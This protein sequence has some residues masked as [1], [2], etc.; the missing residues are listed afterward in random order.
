MY[1]RKLMAALTC[2]LLLA[3]APARAQPGGVA[4]PERGT[5]GL[6]DLE[7]H[8]DRPAPEKDVGTRPTIPEPGD[9]TR[10]EPDGLGGATPPTMPRTGSTH[11]PGSPTEM[12]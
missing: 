4:E 8:G 2:G 11:P 1:T 7:G 5:R 12:H 10:H 6:N 3:A 9:A